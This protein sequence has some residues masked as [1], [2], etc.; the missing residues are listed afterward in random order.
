MVVQERLAQA[1]VFFK[2]QCIFLV[3][4]AVESWLS[5]IWGIVGTGRFGIAVFVQ[6]EAV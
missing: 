6:I 5:G 3:N 2:A 1:S 4:I